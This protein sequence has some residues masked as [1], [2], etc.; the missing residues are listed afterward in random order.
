MHLPLAKISQ[1]V[2]IRKTEFRSKRQLG[3]FGM[4]KI[5]LKDSWLR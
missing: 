5:F 3:G 4:F 2:K 1:I